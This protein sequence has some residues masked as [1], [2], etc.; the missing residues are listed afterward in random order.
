MRRYIIRRVILAVVTIFVVMTLTFFLM[1]S[2]PGTPFSGGNGNISEES[3]D[4]LMS[5]YGLNQPLWQQYLTYVGNILRGDFGVSM[6]NNYR[7]VTDIILTAFPV[8]AKPPYKSPD[9]SLLPI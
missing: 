6:S 4:V 2:I 9:T 1:H 7:S 3:L 8:S 5:R